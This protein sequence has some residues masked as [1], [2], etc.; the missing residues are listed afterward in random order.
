MT[1]QTQTQ[2]IAN[3]ALSTELATYEN[4]VNSL[5]LI[6][7]KNEFHVPVT[8]VFGAGTLAKTD[9]F[10]GR[11]LQE[12]TQLVDQALT[13]TN[14]LQNIWNRSHSQWDWKHINLHYHSNFKNVR[15]IAA[16][17]NRK[18]QALDEAKWKHVRNEIEIKKIEEKLNSGELDYWEE[19]DLKIDLAEK[20]E[21]MA[22]GSTY[23]EGAMKDILSLNALYDEMKEQFEGFT[24][25][26]FELEESKSHLKRSLVQCIRDVRQ[27]G[28]ITKG[29][30]EYLEQIGV[31]PSKMLA[32]IRQYVEEERKVDS[33]DTRM[34]HEFVDHCTKEL[35]EVLQVDKVRMELMG[36]NP[37][38]T[39]LLAYDKPVALK[40]ELKEEQGE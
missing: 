35:I 20:R 17:V 1:T 5:A 38:P 9:S 6:T 18:K 33:W 11:S 2:T 36:F 34:L 10:G 28:S 37:D 4:V 14:E 25:T 22:S 12:N 39:T 32:K 16:E 29:E 15:Q 19:V 31:N 30:Q 23:I 3:T 27:T 40:L 8:K 21:Q 26:D 13:N 7:D 24:E